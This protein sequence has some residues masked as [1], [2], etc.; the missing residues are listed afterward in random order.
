[1][2]HSF[3]APD[4][5]NDRSSGRLDTAVKSIHTQRVSAK[6]HVPESSTH[7]EHVVPLNGL[8]GGSYTSLP[9]DS[10]QTL[11]ESADAALEP[12]ALRRLLGHFATG[13]TVLTCRGSNGADIGVTISAL[14]SVSLLPALLLVC[15]ERRTEVCRCLRAATEFA[16]SVLAAD[17]EA[18]ARRFAQRCEDRFA[19]VEVIRG[20]TGAAL[21][22]GALAHFECRT[23]SMQN[24]GD[25]AILVGEIIRGSAQPGSPLLHFRG[26]FAPLNP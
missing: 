18:L 26:S 20:K 7:A 6:V 14:A 3:S 11:G 1:V 24:A 22:H 25:H 12:I 17:Q 21:L 9:C 10:A 2:T 16:I 13:V 5:D 19:G 8:P 15:V 4:R 23:V